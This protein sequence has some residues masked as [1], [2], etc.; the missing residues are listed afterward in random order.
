MMALNSWEIL[1]P[2]PPRVGTVGLNLEPDVL[3]KQSTTELQPQPPG[4]HSEV[5]P[6]PHFTEL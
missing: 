1:L 5:I 4:T 6:F 3:G 2:L